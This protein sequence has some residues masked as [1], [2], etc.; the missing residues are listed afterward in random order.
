M[1]QVHKAIAWTN[2]AMSGIVRVRHVRLSQRIFAKLPM[3]RDQVSGNAHKKTINGRPS[4]S[5]G[6]ATNISTSC[7]VMWAEKSTL[8]HA[9]SGETSAINNADQPPAKQS[10]SQLRI[11]LRLNDSRQRRRSP[12]TNKIAE[13]VSEITTSGS[14]LHARARSCQLCGLP[15]WANTV[16]VPLKRI[17]ASTNIFVLLCAFLWLTI[18]KDRITL[19]RSPAP[20]SPKTT[21]H[22]SECPT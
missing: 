8:P 2:Q 22:Y 1:C 21:S 12:I 11:V 18:D 20:V 16:L 7:W 17:T 9:C 15:S 5:S 4:T 13:S 14:K 19:S 10:A 3:R 6:A